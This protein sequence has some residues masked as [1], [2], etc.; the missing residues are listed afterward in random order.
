MS[1]KLSYFLSLQVG[2]QRL[3]S[4]IST[5]GS[6]DLVLR[7]IQVILLIVISSSRGSYIDLLQRVYIEDILY[8]F[9]ISSIYYIYTIVLLS[10]QSIFPYYYIYSSLRIYFYIARKS[11]LNILR[12]YYL[13]ILL[14]SGSSIINSVYSYLILGVLLIVTI[15]LSKIYKS[16][17]TRLS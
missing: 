15:L 7:G 6:I 5:I 11:S 13:L 8:Q 9:Y 16:T 14:Y 12:G 2:S 3:S 17:S 1:N 10:S 4:S